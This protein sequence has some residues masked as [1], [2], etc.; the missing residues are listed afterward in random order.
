MRGASQ[1]CLLDPAGSLKGVQQPADPQSVCFGTVGAY[2]AVCVGQFM[3]LA[4]SCSLNR[5]LI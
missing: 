4:I 1:T 5:F 2:A 3:L